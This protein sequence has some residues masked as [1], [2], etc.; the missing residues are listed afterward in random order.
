MIIDS[1]SIKEVC[2]VKEFI[3][4]KNNVS[5]YQLIDNEKKKQYVVI[6]KFENGD[7]Y[8]KELSIYRRLIRHY[9]ESERL[10]N[11]PK[12]L[13]HDDSKFLLILDYVKGDNVLELLE[14]YESINFIEQSSQILIKVLEWLE[15][16]YIAIGITGDEVFGDVNL[17]NFIIADNEVFGVDFENVKSGKRKSEIIEVLAFYMLYDPIRSDIKKS[18][19]SLVRKKYFEHKMNNQDIGKFLTLLENEI[20]RIQMRRNG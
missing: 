6:K 17:R 15:K 4:K 7:A 20:K 2:F 16:F 5:L 3:S 18:V 1:D 13:G 8:K 19:V 10:L 11:F 9:D 12:L 14:Y